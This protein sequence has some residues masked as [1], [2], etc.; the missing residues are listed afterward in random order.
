MVRRRHPVTGA[1]LA[2]KH[3]VCSCVVTQWVCWDMLPNTWHVPEW[4]FIGAMLHPGAAVTASSSVTVSVT[5]SAWS[6]H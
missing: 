3:A 4:T 1:L 2:A 6:L 5:S